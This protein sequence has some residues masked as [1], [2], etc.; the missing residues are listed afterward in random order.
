MAENNDK[1][2]GI[3]IEEGSE[4]QWR[5]SEK[6]TEGKKGTGKGLRR[7]GRSEEALV[8]DI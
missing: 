4:Y 1:G 3:K 7:L 5:I 2:I 8:D 6:E